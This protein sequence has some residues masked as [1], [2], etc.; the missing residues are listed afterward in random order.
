M[1]I[2]V[3]LHVCLFTICVSGPQRPEA[4]TLEIDSQIL[5]SSH[6]GVLGTDPESFVRGSLLTTEQ[7]LQSPQMRF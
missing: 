4:G 6:L 5:V 7:P 1:H 3:F 2:S